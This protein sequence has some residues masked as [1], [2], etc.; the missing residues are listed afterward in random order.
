MPQR[1]LPKPSLSLKRSTDPTTQQQ[2]PRREIWPRPFATRGILLKQRCFMYGLWRLARRRMGQ[3]IHVRVQLPTTS[4]ASS[5]ILANW[6]RPKQ[7][8]AVLLQSRSYTMV[9]MAAIVRPSSIT[10]LR[11]G[12]TK[13]TPTDPLPC[14]G[15]FVPPSRPHWGRSMSILP[16]PQA[17]LPA[18]SVTRASTPSPSNCTR[19]RSRLWRHSWVLTIQTPSTLVPILAGPTS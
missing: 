6:T 16:L 5:V 8:S 15:A 19:P 13:G 18:H 2:G 4:A 17:T 12:E 3:T 9:L 10:L 11:S 1:C 7:R 14:I